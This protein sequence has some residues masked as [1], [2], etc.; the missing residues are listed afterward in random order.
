MAMKKLFG[1]L[2]SSSLLVTGVAF[3]GSSSE[4]R[5]GKETHFPQKIT[6]SPQKMALSPQKMALSPKKTALSPQKTAPPAAD[7]QV[8]PQAPIVMGR[9]VS[10]PRKSKLHHIK[11]KPVESSE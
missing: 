1:I 5:A 6:L 8:T 4:N 11:V 3:A 7:R 10:I 9:S 2:L